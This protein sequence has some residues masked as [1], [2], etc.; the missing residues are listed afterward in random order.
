M[1]LPIRI[2]SAAWDRNVEKKNREQSRKNPAH[3]A[4]LS[5]V[6]GSQPQKNQQANRVRPAIREQ[7]S[8]GS[9]IQPTLVAAKI[10]LIEDGGQGEKKYQLE[11]FLAFSTAFG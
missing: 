3:R 8:M 4:A 2:L 7:R 6:R 9:M 1:I 10:G 5:I 11:S